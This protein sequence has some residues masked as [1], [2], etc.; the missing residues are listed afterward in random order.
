LRIVSLAPAATETLVLLGAEDE[1]VGVSAYCAPWLRSGKR[2]VG[3]YVSAAVSLLRRLS[4][5]IVLLQGYAQYELYRRLREVGLPAYLLPLPASLEGVVDF[6]VAVG[7]LVG[8]VEEAYALAG[9]LLDRIRKLRMLRRSLGLRI[10][11]AYAWPDGTLTLAGPATFANDL[12]YLAGGVNP[13]EKPGYTMIDLRDLAGLK[14]DLLALSIAHEIA[15]R[16]A[17]KLVKQARNL[18]PK[19]LAVREARAPNLAHPG[20]SLVETAEWFTR[21]VLRLFERVKR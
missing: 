1:L 18:V 15:P 14:V 12:I 21:T 9:R 11:I 6:V 13:V 5:D 8:R 3:G 4:P 19:L 2:V 16:R 20:P 10:A 7:G 17:L